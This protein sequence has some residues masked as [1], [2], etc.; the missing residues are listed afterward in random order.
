[1]AGWATTLAHHADVGG[2]VPGSNAL[3]ASEI[4]QE[5]LR[6][7]FLKLSEAGKP[8]Q[9]IW[10]I[11]ALNVRVPDLVLGDLKAQV[12]ACAAGEREYLDLFRRHGA[13]EMLRYTR[14]CTTTPNAWPAPRY[15]TF[16]TAHTV[17]PIT[18]KALGEHPEP[19]V[20][21]LA[22]TIAGD[23][24]VADWTGTSLQVP[25]GINTPCRSRRPPFTPLCGR[26]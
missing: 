24:V 23:E 26:S 22:L 14:P 15:G 5:G 10:D 6:L 11:I 9:A 12:A 4:Y 21:Q 8:N 1:M 25:G 18:W 7:P 3:G 2:I 20:F 16:P 19:I 17:S 13:A